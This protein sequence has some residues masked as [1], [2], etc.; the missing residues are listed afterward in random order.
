[1]TEQRASWTATAVFALTAIGG[2]LARPLR[3]LGAFVAVVMFVGGAGL[4]FA[5]LVIAAG[6]SR[7]K[8]VSIGGVFFLVESAPRDVQTQL[9]GS[10]AVQVVVGVATAAAR[11]YTGAALGVLAPLAGLGFAG[12]WGA[13]H[14][15]FVDREA[16]R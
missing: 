12:L 16:S 14:G 4:M 11:P 1:M 7:T 10:L 13:R 2:D 6:R 8:N 15:A 3:G 9:L 5:A